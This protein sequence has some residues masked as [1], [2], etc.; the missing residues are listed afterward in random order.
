MALTFIKLDILHI[1]YTLKY[2]GRKY[3]MDGWV[4]TLKLS[5]LV[6]VASRKKG[7]DN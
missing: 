7:K 1:I 4:A 3:F 5:T 2:K 6:S